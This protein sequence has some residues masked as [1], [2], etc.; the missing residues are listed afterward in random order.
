MVQFINIIVYKIQLF[1]HALVLMVRQLKDLQIFL[2]CQI[3][4]RTT[5]TMADPFMTYLTVL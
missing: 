1:K 4:L 3:M 5:H 2:I